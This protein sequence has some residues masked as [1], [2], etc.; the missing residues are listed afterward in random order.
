MGFI[1]YEGGHGQEAGLVWCVAPRSWFVTSSQQKSV[2][3]RDRSCRLRC[4]LR[5]KA[6]LQYWHLYFFSAGVL[7][8]TGEVE[9]AGSAEEAMSVCAIEG[10]DQMSRRL[11]LY[12]CVATDVEYPPDA[13][14]PKKSRPRGFVSGSC[15]VF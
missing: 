5:L 3:L 12:R 14:A 9:L 13:I 10:L 8:F 4:S 1:V 15:R 11:F 2:D 7:F 6:R